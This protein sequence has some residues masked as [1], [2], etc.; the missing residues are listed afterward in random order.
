[1]Q[2]AKNAVVAIDYTLTDTKGQVLDT[3]EGR[4]PLNYLHGA[5]NIIPGLERALEGKA[6][7]EKLQVTVPPEEGYGQ[8]DDALVQQVPKKLFAETAE[9]E[10]GMQFQAQGPQ[11]TQ[12]LTVVEVQDEQVTVDANHPLAGRELSFDVAVVNVRE[13]TPDEI[14]HGHVHQEG[15]GGD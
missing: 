8:R 13:A 2:I 5:G 15:A 6:E 11:G 14:E 9:P 7:G 3:S 4:G 1:M 12:L 10:P